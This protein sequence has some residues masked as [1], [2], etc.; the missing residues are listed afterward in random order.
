MYRCSSARVCTMIR[1]N[2]EFSRKACQDCFLA[3][4]D[5][6]K[7]SSVLAW[8]HGVRLRTRLRQPF[9]DC[10]LLRMRTLRGCHAQL[11]N[12]PATWAHKGSSLIPSSIPLTAFVEGYSFPTED[13]ESAP[14]CQINLTIAEALNQLEVCDVPATASIRNGYGADLCKVLDQLFVDA[15]L[16]AFGIG[17]MN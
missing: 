2:A 7:P 12:N 17:R 11:S 8:D 16:Q 4:E 6:A 5:S 13:I 9:S 15:G 14:N 1:A 10:K 3:A